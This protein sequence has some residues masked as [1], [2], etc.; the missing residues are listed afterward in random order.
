VLGVGCESGVSLDEIARA[1]DAALHV[2]AVSPLSVAVVATL[3]RKV[4]EPG[5][6]ALCADRGWALRGYG[7]NQLRDIEVPTPSAV[8]ADAVG[9][10]S[11]SEAA[12]LREGGEGAAL[13]LPKQ[14]SGRVTVAV[15]RRLTAAEQRG[16]SPT[17]GARGPATIVSA[18]GEVRRNG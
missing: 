8:V 15:V 2:A 6:R 9:T 14:V 13:V 3:D 5:L 12:A 18:N 7:A 10:A 11:V 1:V 4:D 17:A 16:Q